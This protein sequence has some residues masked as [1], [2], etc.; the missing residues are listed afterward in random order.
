MHISDIL[1]APGCVFS[2]EFFPPKGEASAEALYRTISELEAYQPGYVSVTYGAGGTT[3]EMTHDLVLRIK[4]STGL[5]PTPHLTCVCHSEE[6]IAEMDEE[7]QAEFLEGLG[8]GE[9]AR[10]PFI[11]AAFSA[12]DY[13]SFLTA[14]EDECRAWPVRRDAPAQ[15]AAGRIH[16]DIERGFIRAEVYRLEDLEEH[17]SE[18]ELKKV[19][20]LR[21]EGKTYVVQD[22]DV[23]HFRFNV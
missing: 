3:R 6:E 17:G 18:A 2:F 1:S 11:R 13:I 14:G 16:S 10:N 15:K 8:L 7:D 9:P 12:L 22:G 21:V 20:K 4:T 5:D 23:M 19:G